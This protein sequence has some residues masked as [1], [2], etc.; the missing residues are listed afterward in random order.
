MQYRHDIISS[1]GSNW[2]V[3][4]DEVFTFM[5]PKADTTNESLSAFCEYVIS[6]VSDSIES[7]CNKAIKEQSFTGYYDGDNCYKLYTDNYPIN[8]VTSLQYRNYPS[9]S[10][11]DIVSNISQEVFLYSNYIELYWNI[12][13]SGNKSI[14]ISYDAGFNVIPGVIK[15]VALEMCQMTYDN[16]KF[17][18]NFLG[19]KSSND[20]GAFNNSKSVDYSPIKKE[21]KEILNKFRKLD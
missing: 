10:Y 5:R 17:G 15:L 18:N 20:G 14:K 1:T 11:K 21:H 4:L 19:L 12:F 2:I 13:P 9:E 6:Y 16:A 3:S 8:S 7:Y